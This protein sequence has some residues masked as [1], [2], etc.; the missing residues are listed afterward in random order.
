V[1]FVEC[2]YALFAHGLRQNI[3]EPFLRCVVRES[4]TGSERTP[5]AWSQEVST[6]LRKNWT[7]EKLSIRRCV[8]TCIGLGWFA[9]FRP[10]ASPLHGIV[11]ASTRERKTRKHSQ[12]RIQHVITRDQ[13]PRQLFVQVTLPLRTSSLC[14]R[15]LS[16][17]T[18]L[19]SST[20]NFSDAW[21][22]VLSDF[23][24]F[25]PLNPI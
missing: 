12:V 24:V 10:T 6:L 9:T 17:M 11:E 15:P 18:L 23:C 25:S 4:S 13:C 8:T 14:A 19:V 7:T 21:I 2:Q 5:Q 1:T 20:Q 3:H 22:D 16:S